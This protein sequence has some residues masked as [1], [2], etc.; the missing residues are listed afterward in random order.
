[1]AGSPTKQAAQNIAPALVGGGNAVCNHKGGTT[2]M[3]GNDTERNVSFFVITIGDM[4]DF[5][6]T[7][8]DVLNSI[9]LK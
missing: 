8:H 3:V 6:N 1:M 5:R 4:G 2:D 7:L 9:Y